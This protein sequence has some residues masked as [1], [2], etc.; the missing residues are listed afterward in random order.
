[1]QYAFFQIQIQ[2]ILYENK[3]IFLMNVMNTKHGLTEVSVK[4]K[5]YFKSILRYK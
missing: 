4:L 1:M 3:S 5:H 2:K